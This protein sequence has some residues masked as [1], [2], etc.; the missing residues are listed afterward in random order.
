MHASVLRYTGKTA[1]RGMLTVTNDEIRFEPSSA[2]QKLGAEPASM[3]TSEITSVEVEPRTITRPAAW[4]A[5]RIVRIAGS[6]G[7]ALRVG[8]VSSAELVEEIRR[9]IP[10]TR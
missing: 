4:G 2:E 7:A 8:S 3:E 1:R 10:A 9:V 5:H 6:A